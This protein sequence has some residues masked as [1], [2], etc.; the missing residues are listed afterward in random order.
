MP[1]E[2]RVVCHTPTPGKKPTSVPVWKYRAVCAA[3]LQAVPEAAPGVEAKTLPSRVAELLSEDVRGRLG[4]V[5]WHTTTV[6]LDMEVRG[7][8][9]RLPSARPQRLIKTPLGAAFDPST[10]A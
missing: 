6:K 4:S 7:L 2:P 9:E 8:I 5:A 1:K 3:V 10:V